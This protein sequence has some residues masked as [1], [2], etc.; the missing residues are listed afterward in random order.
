MKSKDILGKFN[1][2]IV[3]LN[4]DGAVEAT[5]EGLKLEVSPYN[6]ME[7][8]RKASTVVGRKWESGEYFL[9]ELITAGAIM[10]EITKMIEPQLTSKEAKYR[11]KVVIGS[12]PGDLHDI[13]KNL[14]G[15]CLIG[16]GFQVVDLGVDVP[17]EK[18]VEAV[19][20]ENPNI[21]GISALISSTMLGVGGVVE[22]LKAAGLRESVKIIIGG[23][24]VTDEYAKSVEADGSAN[25]A[26]RGVKICERWVASTQ[27][28]HR[29]N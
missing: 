4:L 26:I 19:K 18:F 2:S 23:A 9:A 12:A 10:Q 17:P 8:M 29:S 11:G 5:K 3:D 22:A 13:G 28:I 15:I 25:D 14:A 27:K 21:V 16:A 6:L 1:T 24:P 7:E 20:K